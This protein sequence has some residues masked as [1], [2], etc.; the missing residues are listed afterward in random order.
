M[1]YIDVLKHDIEIVVCPEGP[2]NGPTLCRAWRPQTIRS[3][4]IGH[5]HFSAKS[6]KKSK[7]RIITFIDQLLII[8]NAINTI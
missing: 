5:A 8:F 6:D 1:Q 3:E 2:P 4:S 7:I